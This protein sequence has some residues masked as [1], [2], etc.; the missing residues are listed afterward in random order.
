VDALA[1]ACVLKQPWKR[2]VV[3]RGAST[4]EQLESNLTALELAD[5][6]PQSLVVEL[7]QQLVQDPQQYWQERS[8]L[9]WN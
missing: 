2:L 5:R 7:R 1:I 9:A 8:A 3:G 4:V 6:L